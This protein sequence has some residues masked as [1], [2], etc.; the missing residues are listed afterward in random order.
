[1]HAKQTQICL[2]QEAVAGILIFTTKGSQRSSIFLRTFIQVDK[3]MSK[4]LRVVLLDFACIK[5][6]INC[7]RW[8]SKGERLVS[9]SSDHKVK[10][11]DFASGKILYTGATL[12]GRKLSY[13]QFFII[14]IFFEINIRTCLFSMLCLGKT[15]NKSKLE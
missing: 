12:D 8:D 11:I 3:L 10:M 7:V 2:L 4:L 13:S 9:A 15:W 6:T 14:I 5:G 1:M